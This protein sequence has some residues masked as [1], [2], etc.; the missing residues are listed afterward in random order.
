MKAIVVGGSGFLGSHVADALS[1]AGHD[2]TIFDRRPSPYLTAGQRLIQGDILD[3]A[4]VARAMDGQQVAYNFAGLADMDS[5]QTQPIETVRTNVLG[6]TILLEAA[7][8]SGVQRYVLA[9][10]IYVSGEAGG[11]Y[12]ASKQA[13]ELYVEEYQRRC[14]LDYTILR[15]GTVYGPRAN[16]QNSV[17]RYLLQA[18]QDRRIRVEGTGE[19]LR[20]YVHVVDVARSSVEI[21]APEFCNERVVLTGHQAMRFR[22]LLEMIREMVGSDVRI[23]FRQVEGQPSHG[24]HYTITPYAFRP[25]IAKKLV[26]HYYHDLGQG[27]LH[28]LEDLHAAQVS[29]A[30]TPSTSLLPRRSA[31]TRPRPGVRRT[32]QLPL[33]SSG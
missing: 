8:R 26:S 22:D 2:V 19:E 24:A 20:E 29:A 16:G 27:L 12:R 7:Y 18:L 32:R 17:R 31:P 1:S 13:C 15:Y 5:A 9:S 33:S 11:F 25:K 4:A 30:S 23:E 21:L 3:E 10:T 28:C 6:N 14:G